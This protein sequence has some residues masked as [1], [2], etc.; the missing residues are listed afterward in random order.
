MIPWRDAQTAVTNTGLAPELGV[1]S[2][3]LRVGR[4]VVV[5]DGNRDSVGNGHDSGSRLDR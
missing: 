2:R 3:T 4:R 5:R 1:D